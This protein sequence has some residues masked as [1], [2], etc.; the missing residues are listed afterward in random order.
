[1]KKAIV[2]LAIGA[3]YLDR[4]TKICRKNWAA[5]C[6]RH[7]YD[8]ILFDRPLDTSER[9]QRRSPA[10][11]KC[12]VLGTGTVREYERVVWVDSDIVINPAAPSVVEGVPPEKI[13]AVDEHTFPSADARQR[14]IKRL[15]KAWADAD[16]KIARNWQSFINPA[17]W[18]ALAGLPR[19]HRHI[20]QTGVLVMSPRHHDGLLEHVYNNY[21]DVG[22]EPMNYEMRP[23]SH[24]IQELGLQ[25][26]ID[27]R[28]NATV[29]FLLLYEQVILK[30]PVATLWEETAV[31]R[32]A[33]ERNYF[34]HFSGRHDLMTSMTG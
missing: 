31:A 1:M 11:Q 13:G 30:K 8:L 10:W 32:A 26:W 7:G 22:G 19:R 20:V 3:T 17:D 23:L 34:L 21:E 28:F 9:A 6:E 24:E 5:Y 18:H 4:W 14:I 29:G 25:H 12:L 27:R 16:P 2:T 33:F 15:V